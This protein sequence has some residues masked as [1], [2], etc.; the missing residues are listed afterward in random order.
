MPSDIEIARAATLKPI[1]QV[2]EKLGI[3]DEALHNYGKHIAKLDHG[4]IAGLEG[5]A[6]GK[7]VLVTAISPTPAGEGKTTTTVG[8]GDAL[9]R[10]GQKTMICLREPSLGPCFGM[11]GGAAGGGK[12]QVVPMEQI[13]LHFTGDFHA[14]TSAHS[15]AAA[16][17]DNHVYWANELNI[18][19]RRI[20][21]RRVVD[22][23]DRA[24]R[25]I[26]QSL[27]GVANGFPREDGFDITVA[28]EV[29]AVFCLAKDLADLEERLGRIVIAETRDRKLVTLKDVKATGA[30][31]VLLKDALQPNLVQTL[32][33]NP[34][35]IHGGPF[36]NI[37]HGCNSVIATRAGLRLADYTVTE[38]GFGADL[39]AEK[40]LDIKCRQAGLSPSAV[41]V[42]ATI[43]A[44]KMHGGV[45]KKS[46]GAEN[47]GALETGFANLARHVTNLRGFGLPVVV[48]VNHFHADTDAEHARLK[49]LCRE[50]LDVEAIT[51]RHWAEGGAGAEELA[52]AVVRL[53]ASEPAPIRYAYETEAPLSEKIRAIATKLYGAAD[54]QIE[55][56][57]AGKLATFEKDGYGH[58]PICMAKTQYSFSTDPSLMGAPEG[59]VVGVRDVRL[60]AGAGFVVAICGEIMTMPGLPR[61]PAAD[62]IRLDA[63]GQIDGLF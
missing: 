3:P 23:N 5:K 45:D 59:H 25:Q 44:L 22:M 13:N 42:V 36:A 51:C 43:R 60:S 18:D 16:L 29:M 20:H 24:L 41:V 61:V 27:G 6:P 37:A 31:T 4:Y 39:G 35:L 32:E 58:L 26:T 11:K 52:H 10:I 54:I 34:A 9:N 1:A 21:W 14:I 62:T 48:A 47:I 19:V 49:E 50:R 46:L 7:L 57:A 55:T 38:A 8:L 33:G 28:S 2:A 15:L 17:I 12:A 63:D 40:F 30:M 56:K 53:A